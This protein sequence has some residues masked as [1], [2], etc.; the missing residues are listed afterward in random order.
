MNFLKNMNIGTKLVV[1]ISIIMLIGLSILSIVVVKSVGDS[2]RKDA[3]TMILESSK[4]YSGFV[5]G[6]VNEMIALNR[7]SA[8]VLGD[9]FAQT[10]KYNITPKALEDV[11]TNVLDSG[12]YA[13][14]AFL[15]LKNPLG[16][17]GGN[18]FYRVDNGDYMVAYEDKQP[19]SAQ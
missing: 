4:G 18:S 12:S 15:Y 6:V 19:S 2:M 7:T 14:G 9:I 17:D 8:N 10:S 3:E 13:D 16:F 11:V 5:E 1:S